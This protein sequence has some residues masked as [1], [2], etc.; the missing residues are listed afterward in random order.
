M[1][2]ELFDWDDA[3]ILHLAE[4]DVMPEEAEE[5]VLGDPLDAGFDVVNSEE[6]WSYLGE[7]DEGRILRVLITMRGERIRVLT[8]FDASRYLKNFY[9][10]KKAR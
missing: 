6:R 10:D 7:T 5:V 2:D 8:A 9:I 3:N 4:H 1:D